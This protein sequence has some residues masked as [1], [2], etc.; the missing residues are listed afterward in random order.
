VV[1]QTLLH[2]RTPA[3]NCKCSN[4]DIILSVCPRDILSPTDRRRRGAFDLRATFISYLYWVVWVEGM[5]V[6]K[7]AVDRDCVR[8]YSVIYC[9]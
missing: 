9:L 2:T 5:E 7:R 1:T 3:V 6:F 8:S 4:K